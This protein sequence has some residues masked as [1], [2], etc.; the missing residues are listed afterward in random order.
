[1]IRITATST[2]QLIEGLMRNRISMTITNR[3]AADPVYLSPTGGYGSATGYQLSA[4][5]SITLTT[6]A[7]VWVTGTTSEAVHVI[8][9]YF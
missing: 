5:E 3:D 7:A 2:P 1:V 6:K 8:K 4:G 9:E